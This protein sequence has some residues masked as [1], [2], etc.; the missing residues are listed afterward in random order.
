M[1]FAAAGQGAFV[2]RRDVEYPPGMRLEIALDRLRGPTALAPAGGGRIVVAEG[3]GP[4]REPTITLHDPDPEIE[5]RRLY[6][7]DRAP[8]ERLLDRA[9]PIVGA[10]GG[11]AV[12]GGEVFVG[13]ADGRGMGVVSA[14]PLDPDEEALGVPRTVVADLPARGDYGVGGLA[15]HPTSGRLYFGVGA[16]T[17]SGVVGLDN[18]ARG[19]A[20]RHPDF[21]DRPAADTELLGYRFD[22]PNPR[23]G[24]FTGRDVEVTGPFQ[25][26]GASAQRVP[27]SATGKPTAALYSV[28]PGGGDLRVEA[29]GLRRPVGLAFNPFG[30]LF[31]TNQGM[32]LRG[33][34]PVADDP[35]VVVRVPLGGM[36]GGTWF[37]WPD[38]SADLVP[39]TDA[40]F[41][42]PTE[43]IAASGYPELSALIDHAAS[44]LLPPD[45]QTLLRGRVRARRRGGGAGAGARGRGVPGGAGTT[46]SSR[47]PG[48]RRWRCSTRSASR[49]ASRP[50]RSFTTRAA[51]GPR[52]WIGRVRRWSGR[53]TWR[54]TRRGRPSTSSTAARS[55]AGRAIRGRSGGPAKS[56]GC[57][58]RRCRR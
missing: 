21:H 6:P 35:D 56:I 49:R 10:V 19:W 39:V 51:R 47:S 18:F 2:D 52:G 33:T 17:N 42:P 48:P 45:R 4:G 44:G 40:R 9:R 5:P 31:V 36:A 15:V 25:P 55:P 22:T 24:L 57:S 13:H 26:F 32:Q 23:A 11:L 53:R 50:G 43:L 34:R 58:G 14:L 12:V 38:Y 1:P 8:V 54:P 16:A 46:C 41:A 28:G 30:S 27:A 37:G 29:H 7:P 20:G 3:G